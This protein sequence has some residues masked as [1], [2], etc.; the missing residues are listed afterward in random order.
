[1]RTRT[2][3]WLARLA[4][5]LVLALAGCPAP[6]HDDD[7]DSAAPGDDD[8]SVADDDAGDDDTAAA[9]DAGD[10][11]NMEDYGPRTDD[12]SAPLHPDFLRG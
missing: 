2:K 4:L 10:D 1:M 6:D 9:D 8:T 3:K 12:G 7:D 11:D 5:P